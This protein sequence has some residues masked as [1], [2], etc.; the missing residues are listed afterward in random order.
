MDITYTYEHIIE[1]V[2]PS[3]LEFFGDEDNRTELCE[4]LEY[5]E[6][7]RKK[8]YDKKHILPFAENVLKAFSYFDINETKAVMIGQD[9]YPLCIYEDDGEDGYKVIPHAMGILF[10]VPAEVQPVPKSL[11][12]IF[13]ELSTDVDG[14]KI[15]STG[16]LTVWAKEEKILLIN[17]AFTVLEGKSNSHKIKWEEFTDKL[18]RFISEKTEHLPFI[19]LGNDA[20]SKK[21][22][23]D[24]SQHTTIEAGHPSPLNRKGDFIGSKIFSRTNKYLEDHNKTPINWNLVERKKLR[25]TKKKIKKQTLDNFFTKSN[26]D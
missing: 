7:C 3:W 23:L 22:L 18:I 20:K 16:D 17:S 14:F 19:L 9:P 12:N 11:M 6:N 1:H 13:K 15:P 2:K 10:S 26:N 24:L 25:I 21:S 8:Y 5:V 4:I